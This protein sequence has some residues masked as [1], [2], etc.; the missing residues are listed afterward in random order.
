[1]KTKY[2]L[3]ATPDLN[4]LS[5][6]EIYDLYLSLIKYNTNILVSQEKRIIYFHYNENN[7]R[8]ILTR[9]STIMAESFSL[10]NKL[11]SEIAEYKKLMEGPIFK[12]IKEKSDR[13]KDLEE[14]VDNLI[15]SVRELENSKGRC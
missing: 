11:E 5:K 10:I 7:M 3:T 13:I 14:N 15:Y 4:N 6:K 8:F 12:A 1:M 2:K 9:A